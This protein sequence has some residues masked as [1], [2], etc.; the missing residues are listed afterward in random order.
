MLMPRDADLA[1]YLERATAT[2]SEPSEWDSYNSWSNSPKFMVSFLKAMFGEAAKKEHDFAFH[3]LPKIDR[4]YSWVEMWDRMYS[5][6][7]KGHIA[8]GMNGVMIG[9]NS[10]KNIAALKRADWLVVCE[11]F[12]DETSEFWR[13]PGTTKE[14]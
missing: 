14:E 12:P 13:A 4:R 3:Y 7:V 5:G 6:E 8:F 9:P 1:P 10:Q 11:L 2:T